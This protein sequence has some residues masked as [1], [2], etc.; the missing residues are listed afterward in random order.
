MC[1]VKPENVRMLQYF[2]SVMLV[3]GLV[4]SFTGKTYFRRVIDRYKEPFNYWS[5]TLGFYFLG[6]MTWLGILFC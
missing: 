3:G 6:A 1:E 2:G 5:G 4:S